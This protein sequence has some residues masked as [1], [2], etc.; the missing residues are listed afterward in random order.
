MKKPLDSLVIVYTG[1][2]KGKT[3]AALGLAFRALGRGL[4]V[5]VVQ[6]IK[7]DWRTGEGDMAKKIP[8]IEFHTMGLGFTWESQDLRRDAKA[9]QAAWKKARELI[10]A[11]RH[12]VVIL[13]EI[14][15]AFQEKFLGLKDVLETLKSRPAKINVVVTGRDAPPSLIRAADLVT[16][17]R[18]VKHPFLKGHAA[19]PGIDF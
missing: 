10:I 17:M 3:T 1:N 12:D 18:L 4:K 5:A 8:G 6:F 16:E 13:D 11:G 9:A 7:G 19:K 14:T 2:G 15:Y